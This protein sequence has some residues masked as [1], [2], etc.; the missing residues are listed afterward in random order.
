MG[1]TRVGTNWE[2]RR[3]RRS[4]R[5]GRAGLMASVLLFAFAIGQ[6]SSLVAL[7]Q[8]AGLHCPAGGT[9]IQSGAAG[10]DVVLAAGTEFCV[11]AGPGHTGILTADGTTTLRDYLKLAG[12]VGGDGEGRDVS[13][14]VEYGDP[15]LD[16]DPEPDRKHAICHA[17]NS[18]SNPYS[19]HEATINPSNAGVLNGH[20]DHTGP[21]PTSQAHLEQLKADQT[22]W[23][24][25]VPPFEWDG[26]TYSL[27]WPAGEAI[28]DNGC[29]LP[30][31]DPDPEPEPAPELDIDKEADDGSVDAGDEIGYTVTVSNE[32]DGTARDVELTDEL[33]D[34]GGLDWEIEDTTGGWDCEIDDGVLTCGGDGFDLEPGDSASIHIT[35]PTTPESCGTVRNR[36]SAEASNTG[37]DE[38]GEPGTEGDGSDEGDVDDEV[39]S[40]VERIR[41]ECSAAIELEKDGPDLAHRGDTI[42]YDFEVTNVGQVDLH[43]VELSDPNCDA[44]TIELVDDGDGDDVLSIGE[45]WTYECTRLVT[46]EDADPLP[47]TGT[48]RGHTP[49]GDEVT[50]DDDHVVDL[51]HPAIRIVKTVDRQ[52]APVGSTVTYT[53]VVTNTGDTTLFDVTV[54]DDVLGSIGT[55]GT[56]EPGASVTL[57]KDFVVGSSPITNVGT[58]EGRDV[59]GETVSDDDDAFVGPILGSGG[60]TDTPAPSATPPATAFTGSDTGRLAA[61]ALGLV[62]VGLL[63]IAGAARRRSAERA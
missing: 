56:L 8:P 11:K 1:G 16:P 62:T 32:G 51:I 17:T 60:G 53:Y 13:Y 37:D 36:A 35:S 48:V 12:I 25:I 22:Q 7:A 58:A 30:D 47:N 44:G 6:G 39:E 26:Q 5:R 54:T 28:F 24:D 46:D 4:V 63:A 42:T 29:A 18:T 59:L 49:E 55:I 2:F 43:D 19:G 14:Y 3:K 10:N 27:N 15:D 61:I 57:T 9:K 21:V 41:V 52:L 45:S 23:G 20:L 33:P 34:D 38:D 50:D 31:E 40:D